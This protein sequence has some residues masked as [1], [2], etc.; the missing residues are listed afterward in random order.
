MKLAKQFGVFV[1]GVC[2][3]YG[4]FAQ[5]GPAGLWKSIDDQTGKPKALI[6]ITENNGELTGKIEKLFKGPAEDQNPKCLKCEGANKDQPVI[7]MVILYGLTPDGDEYSGG[8]ILDPANGK[9]YKSRLK[10]EEDGARLQV[11]GYV[12]VPLFGRTQTWIRAQ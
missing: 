2:L 4:A 11:R 3:M 7:G 8:T 10:M 9:Q 12:G 5:G 1:A 6:R